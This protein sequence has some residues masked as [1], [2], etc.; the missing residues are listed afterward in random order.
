MSR[1]GFLVFCTLTALSSHLVSAESSADENALYENYSSGG[2]YR[3]TYPKGNT[4][5]RYACASEKSP[6]PASCTADREFV[7]ASLKEFPRT[8]SR[9]LSG[10]ERALLDLRAD[11]LKKDLVSSAKY[12]EELS[13][14]R[15]EEDRLKTE[16]E[17]VNQESGQYRTESKKITDSFEKNP[18]LQKNRPDLVSLVKKYEA[19][20][21]ALDRQ[22]ATLVIQHEEA[23]LRARLQEN[24]VK[25]LEVRATRSIDEQIQKIKKASITQELTDLLKEIADGELP[26]LMDASNGKLPQLEDAVRLLNPYFEWLMA[27]DFVFRKAHTSGRRGEGPTFD[28]FMSDTRRPHLPTIQ[29]YSMWAQAKSNGAK[30]ESSKYKG[31]IRMDFSKSPMSVPDRMI[32]FLQIGTSTGLHFVVEYQNEISERDW[33]EKA[34]TQVG[35]YSTHINKLRFSASGREIDKPSTTL[36]MSLH[37]T[38]T[39]GTYAIRSVDFR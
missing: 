5:N 16:I 10:Y 39:P 30:F 23:A 9:F 18:N 11:E 27:W 14:L 31:E 35:I 36:S 2:F 8:F 37:E 20:I 12:K 7:V 26:I 22:K 6:S 28:E 25:D 19:D 24:H 34:R 33:E 32:H 38:N 3:W 21:A 1:I 4:F 13:N 17:K 29:E 15:K